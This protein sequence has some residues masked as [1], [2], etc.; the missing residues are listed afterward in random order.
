MT[1]VFVNGEAYLYILMRTDLASMNAGKAVAQGAHAANQFQT[2]MQRHF[3]ECKETGHDSKGIQV[4]QDWLA[5]GCG[6]AGFGTTITLEVTGA[7]LETTVKAAIQ[8]GDFLAGITHDPTYP[9]RDG[10]VTHLIP[11]DT[12][13]FVFGYK[14]QLV[15]MLGHLRLM[16]VCG[17]VKDAGLHM[18]PYEMRK[19]IQAR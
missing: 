15:E 14:H 16:G 6:T 10:Q 8:S 17:M 12:C 13:G 4:Y 3:D 11:L 5:Q 9:L 1:D 18:S 7:E 2:A 19:I